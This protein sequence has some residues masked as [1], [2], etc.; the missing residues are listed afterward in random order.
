MLKVDA[1]SL[2]EVCCKRYDLLILLSLNVGTPTCV[3]K[4]YKMKGNVFSSGHFF[5]KADFAWNDNKKVF[6]FEKHV[7]VKVKNFFQP[8]FVE[9]VAVIFKWMVSIASQ[10]ILH[11]WVEVSPQRWPELYKIELHLTGSGYRP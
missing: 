7:K 10:S 9:T 4:S 2:T 8:F 6:P 5:K 11:K 3:R 1:L